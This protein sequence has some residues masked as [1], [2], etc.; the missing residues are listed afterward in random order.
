V[1]APPTIRVATWNIRAAIGPGEPFPPGWWRHIRRERFERIATLIGDLEADVVALQEVA[2]LT[3]SGALVD[4]PAELAALTGRQVRYA[5]VHAYPLVEPEGGHSIGAAT[6]GNALLT[7]EPLVDGFALGL[8]VGEDAAFVEPAGSG[9]PLAG[10]SFRDAP[11][12]TREPRCVVGGRLQRPGGSAIWVLDTHL[13]YAGANQRRAQATAIAEIIDRL[14]GPLVLLGDLNA[15]IE[16]AELGPLTDRLDDAF[17]A[18]GVP[19]GDAARRSC[20]LSRIDHVLVRGL[21]VLGCEVHVAAGDASD[22]WP[23]VATLEAG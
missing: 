5:A 23:V 12:G 7:E 15:A 11:Y 18:T 19:Q 22:H 8:P 20:G 2:L 6:W 4:Q 17:A 16:D 10:M 9:L 14:D 3:P 1:P 13:A 21:R